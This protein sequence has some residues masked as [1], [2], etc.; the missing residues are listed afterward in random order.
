MSRVALIAAL[1]SAAC[2]RDR[3]AATRPSAAPPSS[4]VVAVV[5]GE[6]ITAAE[7]D[8]ALGAD[9]RAREQALHEEKRQTLESLVVRKLVVAAAVKQNQSEEE[10]LRQNVERQVIAAT[11]IEA[12][13]FYEQRKAQIGNRPFA[14]VRDQ[15]LGSLNEQRQRAVAGQVFRAIRE[16]AQVE[17]RLPEPEPPRVDVA[18]T[19]PFKG[20]DKAPVTIVEFSDFQCPYCSAAAKTLDKVVADYAG[21]VRIVFRD[22]PLPFH[23]DAA[24]AA[25]AGGCAD[26]QGKFWAMHDQLFDNQARLKVP[27]LKRHARSV[28]LDSAKFDACLD[29][30]RFA[31]RVREHLE[32][33]SRAGVRGTPAFFVNGRPLSGALTY[34]QFK[35]VIDKELARAA[36]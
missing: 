36:N 1:L 19:G 28:G 35:D 33:G 27:D 22:Y 30:G 13:A 6:S 4:N 21:R 31:V 17:L 10:Y 25:E 9:Y 32:A 26:E 20:P 2:A 12:Q 3:G 8:A 15:I 16:D 7:L 34:E 18:A 14:E 11:E 23:E 29:S 5:N 24:K